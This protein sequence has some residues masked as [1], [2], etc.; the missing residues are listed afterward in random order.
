L[1]SA[2]WVAFGLG[3]RV[4]PQVRCRAW[5][6]RLFLSVL[7]GCVFCRSRFCSEGLFFFVPFPSGRRN[8]FLGG[9]WF[10]GCCASAMPNMA[11]K[12][13]A[14]RSGWQ[15]WFFIYGQWLRRGLSSGQPPTFTLG[16]AKQRRIILSVKRNQ[17][18]NLSRIATVFFCCTLMFP[19]AFAGWFGPSDFSE[20]AENTSN[21]QK[22]TGQL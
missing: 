19:T 1:G 3:G 8:W 13:T 2:A 11:V 22:V 4:F 14:R 10:G 7:P 9:G 12:L 5:V 17:D 6:A 20:C 16:V 15:S 21:E 18:V